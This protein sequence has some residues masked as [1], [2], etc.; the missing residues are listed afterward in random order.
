M[1]SGQYTGS[2]TFI[3]EQTGEYFWYTILVNTESPKA[4]DVITMNSVIRK[5]TAFDITLQNPLDEPIVFEVIVT[6]EG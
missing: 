6:G 2:I 4:E 1:L 3:D 5:A